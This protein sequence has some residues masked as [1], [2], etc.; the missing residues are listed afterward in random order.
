MDLSY[1][2]SPGG[3]DRRTW[4]QL[5]RPQ[6]M[7]SEVPTGLH[8]VTVQQEKPSVF[9]PRHTGA[10]GGVINN[11]LSDF[12]DINLYMNLNPLVKNATE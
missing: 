1:I 4:N 7:P 3:Q 11:I 8:Q 2:R 10:G 6:L 12:Y 5:H 9:P